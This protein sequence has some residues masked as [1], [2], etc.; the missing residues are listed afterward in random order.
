MDGDPGIDAARIGRPRNLAARGERR[1]ARLAQMKSNDER[2]ARF[3][4][5]APRE[6]QVL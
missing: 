5:T 1:R 4:Q 6:R 3:E 2:A